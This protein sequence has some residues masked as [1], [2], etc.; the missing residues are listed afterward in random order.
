[1]EL[2]SKQIE[3]FNAIK[4]EPLIEPYGIE[5]GATT[6]TAILTQYPLIEPYGIEITKHFQD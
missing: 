6:N 4:D 5:I 2:K 1:M 3:K